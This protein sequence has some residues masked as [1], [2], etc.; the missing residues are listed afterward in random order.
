MLV[1]TVHWFVKIIYF[2]V[3]TIRSGIHAC[4]IPRHR[5]HF[6]CRFG[7]NFMLHVQIFLTH[8]M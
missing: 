7:V 5:N 4:S 6:N 1:A 2:I 8:K 3:K